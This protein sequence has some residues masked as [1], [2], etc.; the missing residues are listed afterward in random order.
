MARINPGLRVVYRNATSVQVGVGPGGFIVEGMTAADL[1]F[2][3]TLR[4]GTAGRDLAAILADLDMS[5][6]RAAEIC[7][8]LAPALFDDDDFHLPGLRGDRLLAEEH[9]LAGLHHHPALGLLDQREDA[10]VRIIGLGRTGA[11]LATALVTSGIGTLLLEDDRP[12]TASDVDGGAYGGPDIGLRR[13]LALRRRLLRLDAECRP[14]VVHGRDPGGPDLPRLDLVVQ[15]G[16]DAVD[17]AAE[18]R[19]LAAD[20]PHLYVLLREQDG[21]V[22]PLVVPGATPCGECLER[23]RGAA[24]PQWDEVSRQL[25]AGPPGTGPGRHPALESAAL[26]TALAGT[27]AAQVLLYIDA[28]NRPGAWSATLTFHGADG[29]WSRQELSAHPDCSCRIQDQALATISST[30]EP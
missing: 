23:H 8:S 30:A 29:C 11:A 18:A 12:V 21:V 25:A 15:V 27:A 20:R 5:F 26:S 7:R 16:H 28:V 19:L 13:S 9:F 4:R 2:V 22:G 1:A 6:A 10:V 3:E 24:D 17:A 14:H